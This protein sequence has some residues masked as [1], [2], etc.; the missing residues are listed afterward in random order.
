MDVDLYEFKETLKKFEEDDF[1]EFSQEK[2]LAVIEVGKTT[3]ELDEKLMSKGYK[4]GERILVV[5]Q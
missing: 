2:G 3:K 1:L 4:H 5:V